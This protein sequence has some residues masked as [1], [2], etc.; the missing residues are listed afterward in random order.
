ME[1][2]CPIKKVVGEFAVMRPRSPEDASVAAARE[3]HH[4]L[5]SRDLRPALTYLRTLPSPLTLLPNH[6]LNALLR[7]LAA[8]GRLRAAASLFR[9]I[10]SPTS[11]SFNS[12]LAVLLRRGRGR[13]R[14]ASALFAA[15]LRS[16][17]ASPDATT[18]NTLLHGLSAASPRPPPP[19]LLRL[20]RFSPEIY[21][22]TPSRRTPSQEGSGGAAPI[23]I[24]YTTMIKA[25]CAKRLLNEALAIFRTMVADGVVPNRFTYNTM[26]QG[27]CDAGRMELVKEVLEVDSFKPDT[28]TF[29]TVMIAHCREG[30]I[31]DAMKVFD[32]MVD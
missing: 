5:R 30:R 12:L 17:S 4:L 21:S 28:C 29:N 19:A 32:Q 24:T 16:P 22:S 2:F 9:R 10:P 11:H 27:F 7:A 25:H 1:K 14:A 18:L 13:G 3:L 6:A 31:E 8:A 20:F 23:V 26:V 15:F